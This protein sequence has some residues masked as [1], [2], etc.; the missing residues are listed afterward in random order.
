MLCFRIYN[1]LHLYSTLQFRDTFTYAASQNN[2]L[3]V[4]RAGLNIPIL[5]MRTFAKAPA[6]LMTS[7]KWQSDH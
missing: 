1:T 5:K 4:V 2:P 7:S 3:K 6:S